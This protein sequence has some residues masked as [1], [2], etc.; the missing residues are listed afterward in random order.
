MVFI[1]ADIAF[2]VRMVTEC[3]SRNRLKVFL[4]EMWLGAKQA[5]YCRFSELGLQVGLQTGVTFFENWGYRSGGFGIQ[6]AWR[7]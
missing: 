2:G 4:N 3:L 7:G 6:K 1:G 5:I